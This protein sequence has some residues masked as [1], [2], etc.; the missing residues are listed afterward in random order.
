MASHLSLVTLG[1][2]GYDL[3]QSEDYSF[4]RLATRN[5]S[6]HSVLALPR[7]RGEEGGA[8]GG[9]G[10]I[11]CARDAPT[12]KERTAP[13]HAH[14]ARGRPSVDGAAGRNGTHT[15]H[16]APQSRRYVPVTRRK[17]LAR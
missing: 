15:K 4:R 10:C 12:Y 9:H 1:L 13:A 2:V 11:R 16:V 5:R 17:L 6:V 3:I 14:D 8:Q 7:R